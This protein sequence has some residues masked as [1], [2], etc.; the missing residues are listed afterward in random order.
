MAKHV[1]PAKAGIHDFLTCWP[2]KATLKEQ[3]DNNLLTNAL[4]LVAILFPICQFFLGG[5]TRFTL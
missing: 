5:A 1:M 3:K 4:F 2:Q